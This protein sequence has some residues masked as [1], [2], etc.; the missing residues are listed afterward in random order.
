MLKKLEIK[1][2]KSIL[3]ETIELGKINFFIGE[4][5]CGKTNILEALAMMSASKSLE[6]HAEGL[7]NRGIRVSRPNLTF[8]SFANLMQKEKIYI[9]LEFQND[10]EIFNLQSSIYCE[11][12]NDIYSEWKDDSP[13][14]LIDKDK[15]HLHKSIHN[16][17]NEKKEDKTIKERWIVN[18]VNQLT[19]YLIFCLNTKALRGISSESKRMPLGINGE[20]LDILLSQFT[21]DEWEILQKYRYLVSWLEEIIV[22]EKDSL[23]YKGHKMGKSTSIL[24]FKDRFMQKKD[25]NNIFSAENANDGVL[26]VLF[27]L[28]LFISSKTPSFFAI[29]NIEN[30]LN[31]KICRE[32][33]K[34][35]IQLAKINC[36]QALITTHNPAVLDGINLNDEEQRLF[37]VSRNDSGKT[38]VKQIKLKP[39]T[40]ERLKLSEMW[41]RG[42]LGGLP[43]NF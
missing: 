42:I 34:E 7:F 41:M 10:K 8:S 30:S 32:L 35:L 40:D 36:K 13:T 28:A 31:P 18:D 6:L 37:V 26:H 3:N 39:R 5:G 43:K 17:S 11:D 4:N 22:D 25:M 27:Y 16:I 19:K 38:K 33:V 1:N 29:D 23:K 9:N 14:Y 12:I 2:Y 15:H 21:N 24:Y 20:S